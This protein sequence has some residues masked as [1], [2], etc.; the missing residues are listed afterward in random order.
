LLGQNFG[1][2]PKFPHSESLRRKI[3]SDRCWA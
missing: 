1:L 2:K 3:W